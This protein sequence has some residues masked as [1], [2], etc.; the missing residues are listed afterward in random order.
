MNKK[1]T[2][3][4]NALSDKKYRDFHS[5]LV[6]GL[7][8]EKIIG[9]RI[10]VLRKLYKELTAAEKKEI[11]NTLPHEFYEE[12]ILHSIII[13]DMKDFGECVKELDKFLPYVDNWAVCDSIRPKI[14]TEDREKFMEFT[15]KLISS[16][17]VYTAR[18][19]VEMLMTY[20]L[21][22]Y[23]KKEYLYMPLAVDT[24]EYYLSMMVAWFYATALGK[25]YEET[26]EF[27]EKGKLDDETM[28]RTV[29][30]AIE[31]FRISDDRKKYLRTLKRI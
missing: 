28:N 19:G 22:D 7:N 20:F 14:L 12:Y 11:L 26:L 16:G 29:R 8:K 3:K 9:V 6:P 18:F 30:K 24:K 17:L 21:D 4:L 5:G 27:L 13:S 2:E 15:E 23:F 1:L 25:Y 10:P 31:S